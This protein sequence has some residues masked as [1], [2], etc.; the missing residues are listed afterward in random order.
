MINALS[1]AMVAMA[2][3]H[4]DSTLSCL[5]PLILIPAPLPHAATPSLLSQWRII[6]GPFKGS[7]GLLICRKPSLTVT[8]FHTSPSASASYAIILSAY[9]HNC[10]S[11]PTFIQQ[12]SSV[13][14]VEVTPEAVQEELPSPRPAP[15]PPP[16]PALVIAP[17]YSAPLPK[18]RCEAA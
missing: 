8:F 4:A 11:T 10:V 13:E 15:P 6:G 9:S 16:P 18:V 2:N 14:P 1:L 7:A 12:K 17:S 3:A 5:P